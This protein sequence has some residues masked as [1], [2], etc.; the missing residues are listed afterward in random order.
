MKDLNKALWLL[1]QIP[2]KAQIWCGFKGDCL[3][4]VSNNTGIVPEGTFR[5]VERKTPSGKKASARILETRKGLDITNPQT[6]EVLLMRTEKLREKREKSG[7]STATQT[8]NT[9]NIQNNQNNF[10]QNNL[11]VNLGGQ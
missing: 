2:P 6:M 1:Q 8:Q 11:N 9:L 5:V 4:P 3:V 10:I 7:K